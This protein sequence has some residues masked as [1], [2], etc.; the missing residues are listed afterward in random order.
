[1]ARTRQLQAAISAPRRQAP[2]AAADALQR[3]RFLRDQRDDQQQKELEDVNELFAEYTDTKD[4][5]QLQRRILDYANTGGPGGGRDDRLYE[6]ATKG[7]GQVNQL[8]ATRQMAWVGSQRT[9]AQETKQAQQEADRQRLEQQWG[10]PGAQAPAQSTRMM[11]PSL[12][13]GADFG[14][15]PSTALPDISGGT[16]PTTVPAAPA[17]APSAQPSPDGTTTAAAAPVSPLQEAV[18]EGV[19]GAPLKGLVPGALLPQLQQAVTRQ[20]AQIDQIAAGGGTPQEKLDAIKRINPSFGNELQAVHDYKGGVQ[21]RAGGAVARYQQLMFGIDKNWNMRT[22]QFIQ[23]Y[24]N[25]NSKTGQVFYRARTTDQ[26]MHRIFDAINQLPPDLQR[27]TKWRRAIDEIIKDQVLSD[28]TY[29]YL[30]QAINN[31]ATDVQALAAQGQVRVTLQQEREKLLGATNSAWQLRQ[32]I[33]TDA[34]VARAALDGERANWD[35]NVPNM[36]NPLWDDA[37]FG[38]IDAVATRMDG[39]TGAIQGFVPPGLRDVVPR[40]PVP[41]NPQI[42][43]EGICDLTPI[44]SEMRALQVTMEGICDLTPISGEM[45]ASF[46]PGTR[47]VRLFKSSATRGWR[48]FP[49]DAR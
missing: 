19:G 3:A 2:A 21:P 17:A 49:R 28:P 37:M 42:T 23:E 45:R 33:I 48:P 18:N 47:S 14:A 32:N 16:Q 27:G 11:P 38:R 7:L 25:P 41:S 15:A 36:Q 1:M 22:Y 31:Y 24:Q 8:M 30:K 29:T 40:Y 26:G 20:N 43:A 9:R 4:W 12:G 10:V 13:G 46:T 39:R 6:A 35:R 44:S 34:D 5:P